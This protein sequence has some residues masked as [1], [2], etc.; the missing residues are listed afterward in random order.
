LQ[1]NSN[2][3]F[4]EIDGTKNELEGLISVEGFPEVILFMKD[5]SF[6]PIKF[7]GNMKVYEMKDFLR[8]H[9]DDDFVEEDEQ[10]PDL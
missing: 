5:K 6:S 3:I 7:E 4:G 10:Q 2:I 1:K 8:L 9:M